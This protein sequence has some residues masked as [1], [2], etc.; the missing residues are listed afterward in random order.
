MGLVWV[1]SVDLDGSGRVRGAGGVIATGETVYAS[2]TSLYVASN[3]WMNPFD[4]SRQGSVAATTQRTDIHQFDLTDVSG[5][6]WV[7]SGSVDG[8]LLNS[9]SMSEYD[10]RLRVATTT[11]PTGP[12]MIEDTVGKATATAPAPHQITEPSSSVTVLTRSGEDLTMEFSISGLGKGQ[13]IYAVRFIG[14]MGYVVTF[15]R[16][17][18]LYVIDLHDPKRPE[19]SGELHI[20]GYSAYLLPVGDGKLIGIGQDAGIDSGRATGAKV[21]LFDVSDPTNPRETDHLDVGGQSMAEYDPHALTWL[22]PTLLFGVNNYNTGRNELM[23]IDVA[24]DSLA[25]RGRL[26]MPDY[27]QALRSVIVG[28][29]IVAIGYDRVTVFDRRSLQVLDSIQF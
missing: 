1:A 5:A 26:E 7:A 29:R 27:Q 11:Q 25:D 13:Q 15:R 4:L 12:I 6:R 28:D 18:P 10:G 19:V 21:S 2:P 22:D 23:V 16:T 20:P 24:E 8:T 17:D 3:Q 14:P 9:Y